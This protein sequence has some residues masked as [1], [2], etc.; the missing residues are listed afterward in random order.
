MIPEVFFE[1]FQISRE[2]INFFFCLCLKYAFVLL[3]SLSFQIQTGSWEDKFLIFMG[4]IKGQE[5][6]F[7]W[8]RL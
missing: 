8:N 2:L 3:I 5:A 7:F 1:L 4:K 6:G